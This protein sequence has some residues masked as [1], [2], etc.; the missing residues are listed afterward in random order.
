MPENLSHRE[1]GALFIALGT[2][3]ARYNLDPA[4]VFDGCSNGDLVESMRGS[5]LSEERAE[6]LSAMEFDQV[7]ELLNFSQI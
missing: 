7:K 5:G 3:M 1:I 4:A 6:E 2:V